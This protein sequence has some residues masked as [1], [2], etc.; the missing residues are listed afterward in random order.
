MMT[1]S[2]VEDLERTLTS[3]L[4]SQVAGQVGT[5]VDVSKDFEYT[6]SHKCSGL[7][8]RSSRGIRQVT[9]EEVG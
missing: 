4:W 5:R 3:V 7:I 6:N 8:L 9:A 1:T 2:G